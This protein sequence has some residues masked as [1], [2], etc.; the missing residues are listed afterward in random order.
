[1]DGFLGSPLIV[2]GTIAMVFLVCAG[3]MG[4]KGIYRLLMPTLVIV[5]SLLCGTVLSALLTEPVTELVYPMVEDRIIRQMDEGVVTE[6]V[7]ELLAQNL[8]TE[9]VEKTIEKSLPAGALK[10]VKRAGIDLSEFVSETTKKVQE[11]ADPADYLTGKQIEKLKEAGVEL[12]ETVSSGL[13][14]TTAQAKGAIYASVF[15]VTRRMTSVA[16]HYALWIVLTLVA[17][18]LLTAAKNTFGLAVHLPVIRWVDWLGGAVVG[19]ALC[20]VV[21]FALAWLLR[22]NGITV[23]EEAAEGTKL[24]AFFV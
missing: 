5:L 13:E 12:K 4:A 21:L 6:D 17:L 9:E 7:L 15:A 1:M 18:V 16:V 19:I 2:D 24:L 3:V 22:K 8:S 23:L 14:K 10:L 11:S 20:S